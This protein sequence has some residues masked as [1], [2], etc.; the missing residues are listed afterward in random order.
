[1]NKSVLIIGLSGALVTGCQGKGG[2]DDDDANET[3]ISMSE[4][5]PTVQ[6]AFEKRH[7][8]ATVQKVEKETHADGTV[9]YEY[10]F[11]QNGKKGEVELNDKGE[12]AAED[13]D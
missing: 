10:T 3:T 1:M 6:G 9:E 5:P 7:P 13:K 2:G 8:D 4:V 11:T 12:V